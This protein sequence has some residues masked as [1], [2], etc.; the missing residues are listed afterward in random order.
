MSETLCTGRHRDDADKMA[1]P[2]AQLCYGCTHRLGSDLAALPDLYDACEAALV[3]TGNAGGERVTHRR[4][5]G[6]VLSLP[7]L[8]ARTAIRAELVSWVRITHEE[9]GLVVWP[10]NSIAAMAVWLGSHIG[11]ISAQSWAPEFARTIGDTASE[12]KAAAYPAN[13]RRIDVG[14]CPVRECDGTLN[15]YLHNDD[16]LLPSVIRCNAVHDDD[17]TEP[18]EWA[19]A[20]WMALGRLII[21]RVDAVEALRARLLAS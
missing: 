6:L 11:W 2:G 19:A 12:A 7:A 18:H 13:V 8:K 21:A 20:D 14:P 5:P 10:A 4:D 15:A 1:A 16:D 17:E 3:A 9:R